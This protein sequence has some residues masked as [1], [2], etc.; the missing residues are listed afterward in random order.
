VNPYLQRLL[1]DFAEESEVKIT[2][3]FAPEVPPLVF[4]REK[5]RRVFMN[6][7][8]NAVQAVDAKKQLSKRHGYN[9]RPDIRVSTQL[10]EGGMVIQVEDNGIGMDFD[11]A[12]RA[13]EPLF[14]TKARGTGL[15]LS[16]VRKIITDHGGEVML[17]SI[18]DKGTAVKIAFPI[19]G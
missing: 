12:S 9:F 4:D 17:E 1:S 16:I 5:M 2:Y 15:G 10:E 11:T 8:T 19:T 14:T 18:P 3:R 7:L 6:L 13:F